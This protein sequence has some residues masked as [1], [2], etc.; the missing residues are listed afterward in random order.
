MNKKAVELA[1]TYVVVFII[2][3]VV[4]IFFLILYTKIGQELREA[5]KTFFAGLFGL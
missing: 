1:W 5:I 2:A 4:F 3:I